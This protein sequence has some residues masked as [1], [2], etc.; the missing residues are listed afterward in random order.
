MSFKADYQ[1]L[2][3]EHPDYG[4]VAVLPWDT[5]IFGFA[6]G[7]FRPGPTEALL[8]NA[9]AVGRLLS[10][11]A[12]AHKIDLISCRV[13]GDDVAA[14]SAA[15]SLGFRYVETALRVTRPWRYS[16]PVEAARVV[17]R[18]PEAADRE[19]LLRIAETAF[20]H[21]RYHADGRFPQALA[22]KRYRWWLQNALD[23]PSPGTQVYVIGPAGRP[24]GFLHVEVNGHEADLRLGGVDP[25]SNPGFAGYQL[26]LGVVHALTGRGV[27]SIV[28]QV[29]ATNAAIMNVYASLRFRFS[30]P[31][32]VFHWHR[33]G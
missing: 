22:H 18:G 12:D 3:A 8:Q 32:L 6:V 21:G 15:Q 25:D 9:A 19:A 16:E 27:K 31:E 26:Y 30:A 23:R 11:R 33:N 13:A 1:P 2:S 4:S 5:E 14:A 10:A 29:S 28:A 20:R 7:D 24:V 17:L